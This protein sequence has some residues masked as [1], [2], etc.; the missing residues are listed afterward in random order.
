MQLWSEKHDVELLFIL[1]G[2]P[3]QNAFIESFNNRVRCEFLNA[4]WFHT[5]AEGQLEAHGWLHR[6]NTTHSL[7]ALGYRTPEE[8]LATHETTQPPQKSVAA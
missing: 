4:Q 7:N 8:F 3:T 1:P 6:Y 2:K 5:L